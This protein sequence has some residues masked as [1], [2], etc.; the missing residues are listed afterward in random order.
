MLPGVFSWITSW[1]Y[2][3]ETRHL[4]D[5]A[6]GCGRSV[7]VAKQESC[8]TCQAD[9]RTSRTYARHLKCLMPDGLAACSWRCCFFCL[10]IGTVHGENS[11]N[12]LFDTRTILIPT[13][14]QGVLRCFWTLPTGSREFV[15]QETCSL[16]RQSASFLLLTISVPK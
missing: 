9:V 6:V 11:S 3:W 13:I 8:R 2:G 5:V 7:W 16:T 1:Q 14:Y 10:K 15:H 12:C 4:I